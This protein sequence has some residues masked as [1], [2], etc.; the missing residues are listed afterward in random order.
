MVFGAMLQL[1][2]LLTI[3]W[4]M[5]FMTSGSKF[6]PRASWPYGVWRCRVI[7]SILPAC[8][9]LYKMH[10]GS[11]KTKPPC[12]QKRVLYTNSNPFL[13]TPARIPDSNVH[14]ANMGPIWGRQNPGGPHVGPMNFAIWNVIRKV[15][16]RPFHHVHFTVIHINS[17]LEVFAS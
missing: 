10:R 6:P 8:S 11:S 5:S 3:N 2:L 4:T 1:D 14:G 9:M 17:G 16:S 15:A 12:I 7:T 13:I